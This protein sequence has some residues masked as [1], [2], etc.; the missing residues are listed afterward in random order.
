ME[1][2]TQTFSAPFRYNVHFTGDVFSPRNPLFETVA[3]DGDGGSRRRILCVVDG[4]L[5]AACPELPARIEGYCASRPRL[6]LTAPP[7]VVPGG[8]QVKNSPEYAGL[9]QQA[10]LRHGIS[11]DSYVVAVGGGA[12]LDMTCYAAAPARRG[13]RLIRV[14]TTAL[15]QS[16]SGV[17]AESSINAH[18]IQNFLGV[19]APPYAVI[20]DW[21]FLQTISERDWRS[22]VAEAIRIALVKDARFFTFLR[23]AAPL[24]AARQMRPMRRLIHRCAELHLANTQKSAEA[25]EGWARPLE[26]GCWAARRLEPLSGFRLRHGE[27]VAIGVALAATYSWL[28]GLLP[29]RQWQWI[30]HLLLALGFTL[31]IP[32]LVEIDRSGDA[33]ALLAG[34]AGLG[35]DQREHQGGR[36]TVRLLKKIGSAVDGHQIR[37]KLVVAGVRT[38]CQAAA[39]SRLLMQEERSANSQ[40]ASHDYAPAWGRAH[41]GHRAGASSLAALPGRMPRPGAV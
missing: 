38:L 20:N 4:G 39:F 3:A 21:A 25:F 12:V 32:E 41:R 40:A 30:I 26:F 2:I 36:L 11:R 17:A 33:S 19:F 1:A 28:A 6:H 9:V 5:A 37:H 14:P 24:V 18:G 29:D 16:A 34:R 15:S 23:T 13:V 8:E 27:A 35:E 10:I 22:G 7:M 31:D